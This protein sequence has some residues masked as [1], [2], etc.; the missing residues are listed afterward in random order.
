MARKNYLIDVDGVLIRGTVMILGADL[1]IERLKKQNAAYLI[2]TNNPRHTPDDLAHHL[3]QLGLNIPPER[4]FT[5]AMATARFLQSQKPNGT[6]FVIGDSGLTTALQEAG[7]SLTDDNPDYVVLGESSNYLM[8]T[9]TKAVRLVAK[10]ARF[11]ATNPDGSGPTLTPSCGALAALIERASGI[12]PLYVGKPNPI[13][14]RLALKYLGVHSE[15]TVIIGDR[16]DTDIIAG[17]QTG[18][19]TILVFSGVTRQEDLARYPY[20]PTRSA[21]SVAEIEIE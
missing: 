17:V 8:E 11:I 9:L 19:E 5:S 20:L 2:L 21:L 18:L 12:T 14:I 6:A 4:I 7:Y 15:N 3:Q 13:M 1:F 16:M 10:G